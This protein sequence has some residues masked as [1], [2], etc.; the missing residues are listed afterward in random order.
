MAHRSGNPTWVDYPSTSTLVSAARLENIEN[1]IDTPGALDYVSLSL[2]SAQSITSSVVTNV[3][4]TSEAED[5]AGYHDLVTNT[6]RITV[7]TGRGGLF[8]VVFN[9][10][11][12]INGSGQRSAQIKKNGATTLVDVL[13]NTNSTAFQSNI[14]TTAVRLAAGDYLTFS[15]WQNSGGALNTDSTMFVNVTRLGS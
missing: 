9:G 6:D 10:A 8:L 12:A 15:V 7:P 4:W 14:L 2:S 13:V 3:L 11:F 1:A 5:A